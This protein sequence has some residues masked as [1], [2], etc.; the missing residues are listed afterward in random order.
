[1]QQVRNE[2]IKALSWENAHA[3]FSTATKNLD[4]ETIGNDSHNLPYT[5][6]Q[7]AEH[8]RFAQKDIVDFCIGDDYQEPDW[9]DDY[10]PES[11]APE[12][13][14]EWEHCLKHVHEDRQRMLQ[15][16]R[17]ENNDLFKALPQGNGQHL[18]REALLIIDHEAYHT[19]QIVLIRKLLGKW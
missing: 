12:S 7:L 8:I 16:I 9:P 10:W 15:L 11:K 17:D 19:A 5:I 1:M 6:W 14:E 4:R 13:M 3:S 2:L 18:F